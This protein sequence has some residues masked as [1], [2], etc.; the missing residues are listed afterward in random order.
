MRVAWGEWLP[1]P[2]ARP[3]ARQP[4]GALPALTPT[5]P[6]QVQQQQQQPLPPAAEQQAQAQELPPQPL[7]SLA[8]YGAVTDDLLAYAFEFPTTTADGAP[9][10][11]LFT[12]RPQRY[13][14]AAPLT[15]NARQRT[16]CE[17]ADLAR[18]VT[19]SLSVGPPGKLLGG[20]AEDAWSP[21]LVA[22]QVG[23]PGWGGCDGAG[24]RLPELMGS[25]GPAAAAAPSVCTCGPAAA[26]AAH[27]VVVPLPLV[28]WWAV[29]FIHLLNGALPSAF[30]PCHCRC[31]STEPAAHLIPSFQLLPLSFYPCFHLCS[32]P[33]PLQVL[34]DRSTARVTNGERVSLNSVEEAAA[35]QRQPDGGT[36]YVFEHVSQGGLVGWLGWLGWLQQHACV[37]WWAGFSLCPCGA[38]GAAKALLS[39][40]SRWTPGRFL[41]P[42][43]HPTAPPPPPLSRRLPHLRL[44]H[45]R[46][47]PPL[48]RCHRHPPRP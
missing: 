41:P 11:M 8:S 18:G 30:L 17:L 36:Y 47:L 40:S 22:E 48:P 39:S 10:T 13:S 45:P 37:E 12:R 42:M 2:P 32:T 1:P 9:L 15:A 43:P 29:S 26:A 4:F 6:L 35:E 38:V 33:T 31:S 25:G 44:P 20:A 46:D 23:G 19:L 16:V 27:S 21:R 3:P 7:T 24:V 28:V 34:I 14:S 5:R